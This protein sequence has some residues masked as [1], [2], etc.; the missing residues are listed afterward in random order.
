MDKYVIE[1]IK[2]NVKTVKPR[3]WLCGYLLS[4]CFNFSICLKHLMINCWWKCSHTWNLLNGK[5]EINSQKHSAKKKKKMTPVFFCLYLLRWGRKKTSITCLL[6]LPPE[7]SSK[8]TFLLRNEGRQRGVFKNSRVKVSS[9]DQILKSK[10]WHYFC[11]SKYSISLPTQNNFIYNIDLLKRDK[12][13]LPLD[14]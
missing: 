2:Q 14:Y 9:F 5:R 1:H 3:R 10:T 7:K 8:S 12:V 11:I 13:Y 4:N 6:Y